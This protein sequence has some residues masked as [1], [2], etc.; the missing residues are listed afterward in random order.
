MKIGA[1]VKFRI[2]PFFRQPQLRGRHVGSCPNSLDGGAWA[3][4][5]PP[6]LA[7]LD[8]DLVEAVQILG[9]TPDCEPRKT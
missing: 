4:Q 7:T 2:W 3:A 8:P 6:D 5:G 1:R 9:G